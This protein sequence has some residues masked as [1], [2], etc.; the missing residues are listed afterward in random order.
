MATSRGSSRGGTSP[1]AVML[2]V[3]SRR[4]QPARV[5]PVPQG[6][7]GRGLWRLWLWAR[8]R[9]AGAS[10]VICC[11]AKCGR[12][13]VI[14]HRLDFYS[15]DWHL[16]LFAEGRGH[17]RLSARGCL[18]PRTGHRKSPVSG[19]LGCSGHGA[20]EHGVQE[21]AWPDPAP[22]RGKAGVAADEP[23]PHLGKGQCLNPF[24]FLYIK[25]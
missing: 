13:W 5:S 6:G 7:V 25:R 10:S 16:S 15:H 8:G 23:E 4:H 2:P 22:A 11:Q 12:P 19:S 24:D 17:A 21:N 9:L 20:A 18:R 1:T 14:P 3:P